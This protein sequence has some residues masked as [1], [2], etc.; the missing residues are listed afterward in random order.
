MNTPRYVHAATLLNNGNVLIVGGQACSS[1]GCG[2]ASAELYDPVAGTF[3]A[4]G[5][6][7]GVHQS[8]TATLL[9]NGNVLIAGGDN[10]GPTLASAELYD[11]VTGT[12]AATG[13]MTTPRE[14]HTA[15]LL[16]N[17]KV[18]V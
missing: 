13:S 2:L 6:M 18:L 16:N 14:G 10:E 1:P 15:S 5:S 8:P 11:P 17:G 4:T 7:S 9:A 3:T 12:F